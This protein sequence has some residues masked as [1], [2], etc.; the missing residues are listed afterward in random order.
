M[1]TTSSITTVANGNYWVYVEDHLDC[2]AD[3]A[4]Y[5]L[6]IPTS[7]N[8]AG[9]LSLKIYPNPSQGIVNIQFNSTDNNALSIKVIDMLGNIIVSDYIEKSV[10]LYYTQYDISELPKAVYFIQ[11]ETE[12]GMVKRKLILH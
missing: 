4:F 10:G 8:E 1:A 9:L 11:L 7:V 3:T 12:K 5:T 6:A 2:P